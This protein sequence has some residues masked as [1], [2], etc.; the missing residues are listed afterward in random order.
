MMD[1]TQ[2]GDAWPAHSAEEN[3]DRRGGE[4]KSRRWREWGGGQTEGGRP[5]RRVHTRD[6]GAEGLEPGAKRCPLQ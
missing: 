6:D 3:G 4:V 1:R 5:P 2:E